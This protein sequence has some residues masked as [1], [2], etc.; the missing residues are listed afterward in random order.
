MALCVSTVFKCVCMHFF[1][2]RVVV[3]G[4][5]VRTAS[6]MSVRREQKLGLKEKK[7][8]KAV[9]CDSFVSTGG[10]LCKHKHT[11]TNATRLSP[12]Q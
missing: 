12:A 4:G 7:R 5:F 6:M 9:E 1:W 11:Q 2:K 10:F 8:V 3:D